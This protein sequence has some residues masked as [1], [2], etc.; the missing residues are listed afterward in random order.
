MAVTKGYHC[1]E[2]RLGKGQLEGSQLIGK[3][4]TAFT[5]GIYVTLYVCFDPNRRPPAL[6]A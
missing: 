1:A 2:I 3:N 6:G 5:Q 4:F